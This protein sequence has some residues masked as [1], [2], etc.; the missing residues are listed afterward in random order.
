MFTVAVVM[1]MVKWTERHVD[2]EGEEKIMNSAHSSSPWKTVIAEGS[3]TR[4]VGKEGGNGRD[5]GPVMD[6]VERL[7]SWRGHSVEAN[8]HTTAI[9][10]V[11]ILRAE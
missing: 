2:K 4:T 11:F 9:A 5:E 1:A 10:A 6:K 8:S 3:S 7:N